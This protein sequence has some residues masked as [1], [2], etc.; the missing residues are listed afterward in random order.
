M[1]HHGY[2]AARLL[3][4]KKRR[5]KKLRV[6]GLQIALLA[7]FIG[8]WELL[9]R[10]GVLDAFFFS[11]PS[12]IV[13]KLGELFKQDFLRHIG[14]TL[15][16][17][18]LGFSISMAAGLVV[19]V[20]LWWSDTLRRVLDPYIV[21]L[22]SLPKIALG[23]IIIIWVG[24]GMKSIVV[25][26]FLIC[27]VVTVLSFL[28]GFLSVDKGHIFLMRS[29]GASKLQILFKLVLPYSVPELISVLKINVG[30]AWVGVI[31]GEYIMSSAGLGHLIIY[32]GQV[33]QIDLVMAAIVVL[34][35]LAGL[36]YFAIAAIEKLVRRRRGGSLN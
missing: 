6:L 23:P 33:F 26:T 32:G 22:N 12:R 19:A 30:L 17:C 36:M 9:T 11:S 14:I 3:Y 8:F 16:E 18:L 5:N 21:V 1:K 28:A 2:S 25:M 34:C 31:M 35:V 13:V 29:M 15:L 20:L 27:I 24:T 4:L 10:C 7:A